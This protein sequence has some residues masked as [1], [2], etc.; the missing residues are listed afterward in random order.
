MYHYLWV[1]LEL[2]QV[3]RCGSGKVSLPRMRPEDYEHE[4]GGYR[5]EVEEWADA[6]LEELIGWSAIKRELAT[7]L[8]EGY[9]L[10]N[11]ERYIRA[12]F[13]K[14]DALSWKDAPRET[15]ND[16]HDR[17]Y[18]AALHPPSLPRGPSGS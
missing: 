3:R 5:R 9:K 10:G 4:E 16:I 2:K 15:L 12:R 13:K 11:S 7:E 8:M 6:A 17:K 18:V 14:D 1:L